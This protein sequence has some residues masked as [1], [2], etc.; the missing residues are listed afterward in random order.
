MT[1]K[2]TINAVHEDDAPNLWKNLKLKPTEPCLICQ[3]PVSNTTFGALG[4][5]EGKIVVCCERGPCFL[6]FSRK[7]HSR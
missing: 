2:I 1:E 7:V 6:E 3:S 5:Y 4:V